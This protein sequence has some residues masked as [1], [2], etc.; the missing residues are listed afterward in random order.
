MDKISNFLITAGLGL[1]VTAG[2]FKS[3]TY[4]VDAGEKAIIFDRLFKGLKEDIVGEGLHFYIP[5]I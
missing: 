3:C 1:T 4:T 5:F 2:F